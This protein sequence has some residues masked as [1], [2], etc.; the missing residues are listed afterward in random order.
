MKKMSQFL[1]NCSIPFKYGFIVKILIAPPKKEYSNTGFFKAFC[2]AM[3][4]I[5]F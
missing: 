5:F 1:I 2:I 4:M 3:Y